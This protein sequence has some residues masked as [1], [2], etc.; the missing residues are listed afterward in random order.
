MFGNY[1]CSSDEEHVFLSGLI[2]LLSSIWA[3]GNSSAFLDE[4]IERKHSGEIRSRGIRC[5]MG[6]FKFFFMGAQPMK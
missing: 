5:H 1:I 3:Y 6:L 4:M 2:P